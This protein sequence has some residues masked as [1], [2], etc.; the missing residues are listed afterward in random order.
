MAFDNNFIN[1]IFRSSHFRK[2]SSI[3][4]PTRRFPTSA[5]ENFPKSADFMVGVQEF[6]ADITLPILM[7]AFRKMR[8]TMV[9]PP[10]RRKLPA[11]RRRALV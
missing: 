9:W 2:S 5:F 1:D 4:L 11:D 3:T 8:R 10:R 7:R 6:F